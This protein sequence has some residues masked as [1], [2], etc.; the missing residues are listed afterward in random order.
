MKIFRKVRRKKHE[1]QVEIARRLNQDDFLRPKSRPKPGIWGQNA[2][3]LDNILATM[4]QR[5]RPRNLTNRI[6][7]QAGGMRNVHVTLIRLELGTDPMA[8]CKRPS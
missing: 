3:V 6:I 7:A 4:S 2:R 1:L 8:P 5:T